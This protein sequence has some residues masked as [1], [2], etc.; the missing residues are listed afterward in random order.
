[1]ATTTTS[2]QLNCN[3]MACRTRL[4]SGQVWVTFCSHIFCDACGTSL[5]STLACISCRTDL[6]GQFRLIKKTL[7]PGIEWKRMVLAGLPPETVMEISSSA[8][9]FYQ[10]Q[11]SQEVAY[12][13]ERIERVMGR[14]ESVKQYYEGVIE[15][16]KREISAL[17]AKL[18]NTSSSFNMFNSSEGEETR[19]MGD[20]QQVDLGV[21]STLS[22]GGGWRNLGES[23][24]ENSWDIDS[25]QQQQ[26]AGFNFGDDPTH[27][28][29]LGV[30]DQGGGGGGGGLVGEGVGARPYKLM[31]TEITAQN[32]VKVDG[33]NMMFMER[34]SVVDNFNKTKTT[35]RSAKSSYTQ[36]P[37]LLSKFVGV[38]R[39]R[40]A[41]R[42]DQRSKGN[43]SFKQL[44]PYSSRRF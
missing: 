25:P 1:M 6:S 24:G 27:L 7:H 17:E 35:T 15:Q 22:V 14:V 36:L 39:T 9:Q 29:N 38:G 19:K 13:E 8:I 31:R 3:N 32:K 5:T 43:L 10:H 34:S 26:E 16:F 40:S 21:P 44:V 4:S 23:S 33:Q 20:I 28:F 42:L 2:H 12:L 37:L 18:E 11:T 30:G 41:P